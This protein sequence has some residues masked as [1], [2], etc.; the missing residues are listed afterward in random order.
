MSTRQLHSPQ[1]D[2]C[3]ENLHSWV[4]RHERKRHRG[5]VDDESPDKESSDNQALDKEIQALALKCLCKMVSL[6]GGDFAQQVVSAGG[7]QCLAGAVICGDA[8]QASQA[9]SAL[10]CIREKLPSASA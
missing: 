5:R 2:A 3:H 1:T 7:L 10:L 8:E 6:L 4:S 9:Q